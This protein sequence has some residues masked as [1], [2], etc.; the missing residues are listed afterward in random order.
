MQEM[1]TICGCASVFWSTVVSGVGGLILGL[2]I[3]WPQRGQP[4]GDR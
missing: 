4:R 2:A 1:V 3:A